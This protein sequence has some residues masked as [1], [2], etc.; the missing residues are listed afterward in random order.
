MR[1]DVLT[2]FPAMFASPLEESILAK[3][4]ARGLIEIRVH[5]LRDFAE[6]KHRAVDDTPY[7]GEAGMVM[8]PEPLVRGIEALRAE[9][10]AGRVVFLTPQGRLLDQEVVKKLA[11][12]ERL[13]LVCGR[14][15]GIDERVRERFVDEEISIGDYVVTG[16]ELPAMVLID[17][18]SRMI[19][20]VVGKSQCVE[21]DSL[22]EGLLKHPQYTRPPEFRGMRVPDVLL[23]G[24]HPEI[25]RWRRAKSL[26]RTWR[27]RPD[28]LKKA[29][30]T[31]QDREILARLEEEDPSG[32]TE[33]RH[34]QGRE[35]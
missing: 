17:A 1:F 23:S 34:E 12:I 30:L 10:G 5:D 33:R 29:P 26:E 3:A 6:G 27:L 9:G 24:N 35:T 31:D 14:Y 21:S 4:S 13:I 15:E 32:P 11:T 25:E 18:V 19:P 22:Y 20:N 8:K 7:G 2:I 16:G 28:I